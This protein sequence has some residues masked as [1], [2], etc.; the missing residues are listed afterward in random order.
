MQLNYLGSLNSCMYGSWWLQ[1]SM[2]HIQACLREALCNNASRLC[3]S[4]DSPS[5]QE[6]LQS[7]DAQRLYSEAKY[8]DAK[9]LGI[10]SEQAHAL[11]RCQAKP[12][13]PKALH[14]ECEWLLTI[15]EQHKTDRTTLGRPRSATSL[16]APRLESSM[17]RMHIM[18]SGRSQLEPSLLLSDYLV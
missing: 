12:F 17:R 14:D 13:T 7:G 15:I 1:T 10:R 4:Q 8:K 5:F 18:G 3:Q 11:W 6:L 2:L 16:C 9:L